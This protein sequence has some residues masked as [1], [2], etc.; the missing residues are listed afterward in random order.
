MAL[1]FVFYVLM[2]T[3]EVQDTDPYPHI[4]WRNFQQL[5]VYV[6]KGLKAKWAFAADR[7]KSRQ[8]IFK[9]WKVEV[10]SDSNLQILYG[11]KCK[12]IVWFGVKLWKM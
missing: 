9:T 8:G 7:L 4:N 12:V 10:L 1:A 5:Q 3:S 2:T 6:S 11:D